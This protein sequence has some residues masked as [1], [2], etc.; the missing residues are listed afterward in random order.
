VEVYSNCGEV[1]LSL[2]GKSLGAQNLPPDAAPRAWHMAFESGATAAACKEG[3]REELRTANKA[4]KITLS[5]D[6][7]RIRNDLDDVAYVAASV[8]DDFGLI[9]PQSAAPMTFRIVGPGMI[10]AVDSADNTSHEPFRSNS[11]HAYDGSCVAVIRAS[12][13]GK[14][15]VTASAPG[16]S[17]ATVSIEAQSK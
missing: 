12:V 13:A 2:N 7:S 16:L 8:T 15:A 14:I 3:P 1:T 17:S 4:S 5:I 10:A 9:V 6:R 11:R